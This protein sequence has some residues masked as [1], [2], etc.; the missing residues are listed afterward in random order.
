[1]ALPLICSGLNSAKLKGRISLL[2][3]K[4]GEKGLDKAENLVKSFG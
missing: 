3:S 1:M 4:P 2:A